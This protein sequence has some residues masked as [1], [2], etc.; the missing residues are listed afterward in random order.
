M[1]IALMVIGGIVALVGGIGILIAA[2]REGI[3]WGLGCL[4][5]PLVSLIFVV[6]HWQETKK[7]FLLNL[8][9]AIVMV[10]GAVIQG[11]GSGLE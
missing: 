2:F 7:P 5:V 6:T 3:V 1:G 4:V 9:G 8:A 10:V 11:P